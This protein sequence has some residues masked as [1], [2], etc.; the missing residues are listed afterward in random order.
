MYF[1]PKSAALILIDL[2]VGFCGEEGHTAKQG[3]NVS[4]FKSV[5]DSAGRLAAAVRLA[6]MPVILTRMVYAPD[7]SNGG[8][9]TSALR[10]NL[11]RDGAL[12]VDSPDADIMPEL[13]AQSSDIILDKQR[14][15][16]L[17]KTELAQILVQKKIDSVVVG[18][19]TTSMCVE[20]T[21]RDLAM[22]DYKC[23]IVP[24]ACGD[25]N[26]DWG[27]RAME[28]FAMAFG[29]VVSETEIIDAIKANG[30]EFAIQ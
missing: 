30:R 3:R 27:E 9:T 26:P 1:D 16:A 23:F 15:S 5:L 21:V 20:S 19:V 6:G 25:L 2:Q 24:E 22:Y 11:E 18:G 10:P 17:I 28:L 8:L 7:Y 12:R 4:E 29:R 13:N 14:Y